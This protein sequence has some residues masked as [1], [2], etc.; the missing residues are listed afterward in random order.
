MQIKGLFG[1]IH[2]VVIYP[3]NLD[4]DIRRFRNLSVYIPATYDLWH[5]FSLIYW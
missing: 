1:I 5:I 3:D 4:L 2:L